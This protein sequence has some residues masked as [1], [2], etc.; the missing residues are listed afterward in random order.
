MAK[1]KKRYDELMDRRRNLAIQ[2]YDDTLGKIGESIKTSAGTE[3]RFWLETREKV[4]VDE[5]N[6]PIVKI[7]STKSKSICLCG[8]RDAFT[9][10]C[11]DNAANHRKAEERSDE[12]C[13]RELALLCDF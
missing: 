9:S 5:L 2:I 6:F 10:R 1:Y 8:R 11:P 13:P 4:M 12:D 3:W 7:D